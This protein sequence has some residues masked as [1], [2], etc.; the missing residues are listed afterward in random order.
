MQ[1]TWKSLKSN[2]NWPILALFLLFFVGAF[3]WLLLRNLDD[4]RLNS[5]TLAYYR[6]ESRL[7]KLPAQVFLPS[8]LEVHLLDTEQALWPDLF[9]PQ[10]R[11]EP[12]RLPDFYSQAERLPSMIQVSRAELESA[13]QRSVLQHA[14]RVDELRLSFTK[15]KVEAIEQE[16]EC[17]PL[18]QETLYRVAIAWPEL[19]ESTYSYLERCD[20][21]NLHVKWDRLVK[22]LRAGDIEGLNAASQSFQADFSRHRGEWSRWFAMEAS[23]LAHVMSAR[24][25][26]AKPASQEK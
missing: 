7:V 3:V 4:Y 18:M 15:P 12:I 9:H 19:E 24:L 6:S 2:K 21:L 5:N 26:D 14:G 22:S 17:S 13:R 1:D 11:L 10:N 23:Q 8:P 20:P 16:S 25:Q